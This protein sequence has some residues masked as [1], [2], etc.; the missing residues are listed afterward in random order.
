MQGGEG[1]QTRTGAAE[2][3]VAHYAYAAR[4][5][6]LTAE[7]KVYGY[8]LLYRSSEENR[9]QSQNPDGATR[10]VIDMSSL[11][12]LDIL[13]DDRQ[14]FLNCTRDILLSEFVTLLPPRNV[15]L[16]VLPEVT[17]DEDVK[18][19][20]QR[21]KE[22]GYKIALDDFRLKDPREPLV[23][24]ADF[25]KV[26]L[27]NT[28]LKEAEAISALRGHVCKMVAQKVETREDYATAKRAG[29]HL[30]QGYFFRRPQ[31][32]RTWSGSSGQMSSL[33]LLREVSR[34]ELD[35]NEV[36]RVIKCD[37]TL[38]YRLLRYLNSPYFGFRS[39]IR[40]VRQALMILGEYEVR[41]WCRLAVTVDMTRNKPSDLLL[42][43]LTRAR[44]SELLGNRLSYTD[45]D[46]FLL[47]LLSLMDS[48]LEIPMQRAVDA[49]H[50]HHDLAAALVG[51]ESNLTPIYH[52]VLAVEA[53]AWD[54]AALWCESLGLT[55][56]FVA[57]ALWHAMEW[58]HDVSTM[59]MAA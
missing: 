13:C 3:R 21:L 37:A 40:T 43:T 22:A 30:F 8:E 52:L 45:S 48:I 36:E 42:A 18:L 53:G 6:I 31:M 57:E 34:A 59:G 28:P 32:V 56:S 2:Q 29:F 1:M 39:E 15:V 44:L 35:W 16:E 19:A 7:E 50:V 26:D 54:E 9:F 41:R 25:V 24:Y 14:A 17:A 38:C 51:E 12:G 20:L 11:L 4:Q 47:G 58:A 5:P 46:L 10:S 55:E 49:L 27:K 23:D 33:N